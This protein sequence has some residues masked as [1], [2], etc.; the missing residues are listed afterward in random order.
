MRPGLLALSLAAIAAA[1]SP[2]FADDPPPPPPARPAARAVH[3]LAGELP[4]FEGVAA[5]RKEAAYHG[6]PLLVFF[7]LPGDERC[8]AVAEGAFRDAAIAARAATFVLVLAD[9]ESEEAFGLEHGVKRVPTILLLDPRGAEAGRVEG[10]AGPAEVLAAIEAADRK[11]GRVPLTK[12]GRAIADASARLA[13]AREKGDWRRAL[14]AAADL[15][16]IGHEGRELEDARAAVK[17]AEAA[18]KRRLD[19]AKALIKDGKVDEARAAFRKIAREFEGLDAAVEAKNL[20]LELDGPP[21]DEDGDG[22][23]DDDGT[24]GKKGKSGPRDPPGTGG[25]RRGGR[26]G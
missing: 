13:A 15:E 11:I 5:G 17:D 24:K 23:G 16:E 4:F 3:P 22:T 8:R 19:A 18:A 2:A 12:A 10:P 7:H 1:P 21:P 20:L 9:A 6:K 14:R 26:R 25:R